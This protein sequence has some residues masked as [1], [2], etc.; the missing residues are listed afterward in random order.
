M[1]RFFTKNCFVLVMYL[2]WLCSYAGDMPKHYQPKAFSYSSQIIST[3][4]NGFL[5]L[6]YYKN[7]TAEPYTPVITKFD[8]KADVQ[9]EKSLS[10]IQLLDFSG[11]DEGRLFPMQDGYL[12]FHTYPSVGNN[13]R[14]G[15]V[16]RFD[17]NWNLVYVSVP[18]LDSIG[19]DETYLNG[20]NWSMD[21]IQPLS[22]GGYMVIGTNLADCYNKGVVFA[23]Y[24]PTGTLVWKHKSPITNS[25]IQFRYDQALLHITSDNKLLLGIG[26]RYQMTATTYGASFQLNKKTLNDNE[27]WSKTVITTLDVTQIANKNVLLCQKELANGNLKYLA[28]YDINGG[29]YA[30]GAFLQYTIS[31]TDGTI[32]QIDTFAFNLPLAND[33]NFRRVEIDDEENILILGQKSFTKLD[34]KG[35]L[36]WQR[37]P[38]EDIRLFDVLGTKYHLT[39]FTTTSNGN[40]LLTGNNLQTTNANSSGIYF[41]LITADGQSKVKALTGKVYIDIDK[42]CTYTNNETGYP[43]LQVVAERNGQRHYASTDTS[44]TY[45][46]PLD[47]G[48]YNITVQLPNSNVWKMCYQSY[49]ANL[50]VNQPLSFLNIPLYPKVTCPFLNVEIGT[51]YLRKCAENYYTL[52]YCNTGNDT[53]HSTYIDVQLDADMSFT[54]ADLSS[55]NLG[56]NQYRFQLGNLNPQNCGSFKIYAQL[57]CDA[58]AGKTHCTS[59]H[60]YPDNACPPV[61][62]QWDGSD[63]KLYGYCQQDSAIIVIKN[64]GNNMQSPRHYIVIEGDFL[65]IQPQNYQ[66]AANDSIVLRLSAD[67][68]TIRVSAQQ[69]PNF[70]YPSQPSITIESCSGV[71]DSTGLVN[72]FPHDDAAAFI[73]TSCVQN[74]SSFD[75]NEKMAQPVGY[76][77]EHYVEKNTELEYTLR[78]QNMGNDT[79]FFVELLD[80]LSTGLDLKTLVMGA[81]SHPYNYAV[82][83]GHILQINF[84]GIKLPDSLTN[85][86]MSHG[87]VT[88]HIQP[89]S[90]IPNG[91]LIEN[92]AQ[93]YFDY[94]SAVTTN[95]IYHTVDSIRYKIVSLVNYHPT[96]N[97]IAVYPNP[98]ST[99]AHI[100]IN[101]SQPLKNTTVQVWSIDGKLILNQPLEKDIDGRLLTEGMYILK[102]LA[103]GK[104]LA[105]AKLIKQ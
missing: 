85:E 95:T 68:Q 42:S 66:L 16:Q 98:F 101:S 78:F 88:F 100:E 73:S 48:I 104:L 2:S 60:I 74:R 9:W 7:S 96:I 29:D 71:I 10:P 52:Y 72:Q 5:M 13:G 64:T 17:K 67:G 49:M 30:H 45:Y 91:T 81:S 58:I 40:Y 90:T 59:A 3:A 55:I 34:K 86:P 79:A 76:L 50:T 14:L 83:G 35:N 99:F 89:K 36:I 61:A 51:P 57:S 70:P 75:P 32:L 18:S 4:D 27:I 92:N 24:S 102:I 77:Q 80:T 22:D 87:F 41:F 12:V 37:T 62:S 33:E 97:K 84:P 56:N 54:H 21:K 31:G 6:S 105:T 103:E 82:Y 93:I 63:I 43:G 15:L 69:D 26:N 11:V 19:F 8:Q 38:F 25:C 65:R 47:S 44:G 46:M 20:W 39:S 53:A 28:V 23:R 1:M 94:N